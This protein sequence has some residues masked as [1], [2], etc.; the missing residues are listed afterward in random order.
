MVSMG[1]GQDSHEL[2][3]HPHWGCSLVLVAVTPRGFSDVADGQQQEGF[4]QQLLTA[5]ITLK[6][7]SRELKAP[8]L[9]VP[10]LQGKGLE[11]HFGMDVRKS[12]PQAG[13]AE[14]A[15]TSGL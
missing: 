11:V 7:L 6:I 15:A 14:P 2:Q 8:A 10:T 5:M 4:V 1:R 12:I 3:E 13:P 9:Q